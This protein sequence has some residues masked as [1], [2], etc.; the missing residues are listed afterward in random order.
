MKFDF[1]KNLPLILSAFAVVILG[2]SVGYLIYA[3][4]LVGSASGSQIVVGQNLNKN[5]VGTLDPNVKY[6]NA[7]GTLVEGGIGNEGTHHLERE[8]GPSKNAYLTSSVVD[9][10]SYVGKKVEVW[11]QTMSSKKSGWLMDVAKIK[12]S[13]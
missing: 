10:Q 13:Q 9:L 4:F 3:K 2:V 6:D 7:V 5:E 12:I 8:G 1:K 11:G